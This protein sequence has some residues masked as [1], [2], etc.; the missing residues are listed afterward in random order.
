MKISPRFIPTPLRHPAFTMSELMVTVAVLII[1]A[2]IGLRSFA[3]FYEQ[4]KLRTAA[5][6][7]AALLRNSRALAMKNNAPCQIIRT[8]SATATFGADTTLTGNA[9]VADPTFTPRT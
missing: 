2:A 6:A 9:C 4:Q 8:D 7:L 5:L 3:G 1:F